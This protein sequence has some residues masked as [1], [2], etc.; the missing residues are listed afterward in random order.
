MSITTD[1]KLHF[2]DRVWQKM[3]KRFTRLKSKSVRVGWWRT[4]YSDGISVAQVAAWNE[5]GHING[6]MFAGTVTPPRPFIRTGFSPKVKG[7]LKEYSQMLLLNLEGAL[8]VG[9]FWQSFAEELKEKMKESILDFSV[10]G[11]SNVTIQMKGFDDP[12]I[13]SGTMYDNVKT[14]IRPFIEKGG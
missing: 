10:P 2:D 12:L 4:Q 9:D 6:G 14:M 13:N 1:V 8:G 3:E 7:V 11:N 5:E